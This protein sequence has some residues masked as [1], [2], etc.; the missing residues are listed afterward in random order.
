MFDLNLDSGTICESSF[1]FRN[2]ANYCFV[3]VVTILHVLV[4]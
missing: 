3:K 2:N 4:K 1:C